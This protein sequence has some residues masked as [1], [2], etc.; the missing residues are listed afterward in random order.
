MVQENR[1][2]SS[3][4]AASVEAEIASVTATSAPSGN[5]FKPAVGPFYGRKEL[6]FGASVWAPLQ[7]SDFGAVSSKSGPRI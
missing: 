4:E 5:R 2:V 6:F 3:S 7:V 1:Q